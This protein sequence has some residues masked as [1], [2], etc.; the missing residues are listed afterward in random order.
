MKDFKFFLLAIIAILVIALLAVYFAGKLTGQ[1]WVDVGG[2]Y[3]SYNIQGLNRQVE[4]PQSVNERYYPTYQKTP[5]SSY[6]IDGEVESTSDS[7]FN[8]IQSQVIVGSTKPSWIRERP[9]E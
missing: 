9:Y 5:S 7:R 6:V 1:V 3:V 8:P 2:R 4:S